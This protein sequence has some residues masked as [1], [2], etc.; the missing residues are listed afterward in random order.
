MPDNFLTS[1]K[2]KV[3]VAASLL[4]GVIDAL[5]VMALGPSRLGGS[6]ANP[7]HPY[8]SALRKFMFDPATLIAYLLLCGAMLYWASRPPLRKSQETAK[9]AVL[10]MVAISVVGLLISWFF[11]I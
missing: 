5:L 10:G 4:V 1:G 11:G 6:T 3:V 8:F 2:A 9:L 7:W